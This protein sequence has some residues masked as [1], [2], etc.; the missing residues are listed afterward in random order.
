MALCFRARLLCPRWSVSIWSW[1]WSSYSQQCWTSSF[2]TRLA[3]YVL[4]CHCAE[5]CL[6]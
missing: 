5:N 6:L 4:V 1:S 2:S 3:W